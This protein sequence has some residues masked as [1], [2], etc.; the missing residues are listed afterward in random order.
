MTSGLHMKYLPR[1]RQAIRCS[2]RSALRPAE[3]T[4]A[5]A[6]PARR[7]LGTLFLLAACGVLLPHHARAALTDVCIPVG[8]PTTQIKFPSRIAVTRKT[9]I[10]SVLATQTV[11]TTIECTNKYYPTGSFAVIFKSPY[12]E[13]RTNTSRGFETSVSG[14]ALDWTITNYNGQKYAFGSS[15]LN[16]PLTSLGVPFPHRPIIPITNTY[17]LTHTF[18]L[19]RTGTVTGGTFTFP[20]ITMM[21]KPESFFGDKY[22]KDLLSF[23]FASAEIVSASCDVIKN[24]IGVV[25]GR[26]PQSD[27]NGPG[28]AAQVRPFTIDL[29]CTP[30]TAVSLTLDDTYKNPGYPGTINLSD[31]TA[32][33]IGIQML[34]TWAN[35]PF[36]IGESRAVGV[37]SNGSMSIGLGARYIQTAPRVTGGKANGV[38]TFTLE[39]R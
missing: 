19:I 1:P 30:G 23:T 26:V 13:A 33:G 31:A 34:D 6:N 32:T 2:H 14:I 25:L 28:T 8:S 37:T 11:T 39:Y 21:S 27:F 35:K 15:P 38:L 20:K 7:A 16:S 29:T 36:P 4:N 24:N 3:A 18:E 5:A 22:D 9:P 12:N 17:T 10:G